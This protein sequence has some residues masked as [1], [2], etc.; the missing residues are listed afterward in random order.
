MADLIDDAAS[1]VQGRVARELDWFTP[2]GSKHFDPVS[3]VLGF[4]SL[5]VTAFVAG[6]VDEAL[7]TAKEA[8]RSTF[9][10]LSGLV[11]QF[12]SEDEV[13]EYSE[14]NVL[15]DRVKELVETRDAASISVLLEHTENS[16]RA[17]LSANLPPE[18]A[19]NLAAEIRTAVQEQM[20]TM[21]SRL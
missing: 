16:F 21:T 3:T 20:L 14:R 13:P 12:F 1:A 19:A 4:A 7:G 9:R 5:L 17:E 15:T 18:R 6:F 11:K 2:P 8:G 10:R